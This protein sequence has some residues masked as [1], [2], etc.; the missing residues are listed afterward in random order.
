MMLDE[1]RDSIVNR[2]GLTA[3][4]AV[5]I[6]LIGLTAYTHYLS[7]SSGAFDA[8]QDAEVWIV[9]AASLLAIGYVIAKS[10]KNL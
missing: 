4:L 6:L 10:S 2:F 3:V 1:R 7:P 5:V 8:I 9:V